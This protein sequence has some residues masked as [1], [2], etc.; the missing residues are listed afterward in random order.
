LLIYR[1]YGAI[2]IRMLLSV[3]EYVKPGFQHSSRKRVKQSKKRKKLH[4]FDFQKNVKNVKQRKSNNMY[5][6]PKILGLNTTL[7]QVCC[8]LRN[9]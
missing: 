9:Y 5:C 1:P 6:M 3:S 7:N 2:Q 4:F 8:P